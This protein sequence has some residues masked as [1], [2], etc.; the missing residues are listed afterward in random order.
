MSFDFVWV[1]EQLKAGQSVRRV[2][3]KTDNHIS[4]VDGTVRLFS[5]RTHPDGL[6]F[7]PTFSDTQ[8]KDWE[9]G[10][11]PHQSG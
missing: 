6:V 11:D 9:P 1:Q 8:A 10:A 4:N 7:H 5:H 2:V 3:W